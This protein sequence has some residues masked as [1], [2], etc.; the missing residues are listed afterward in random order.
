M[1]TTKKTTDKDY[2][3]SIKVRTIV[4][5]A[6]GA[7]AKEAIENLQVKNGKGV[8][9]LTVSKGKALQSKIIAPAQ[10]QSLFSAS[11]L[12]REIALKN[13]IMRFAI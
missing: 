11:P 3:A 13:V 10:V 2:T 6:K 9:V 8:G 1:K 7:T 5:T 4:S 12:R